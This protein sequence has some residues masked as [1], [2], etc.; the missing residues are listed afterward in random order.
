MWRALNSKLRKGSCRKMRLGDQIQKGSSEKDSERLLQFWAW[1][2]FPYHDF[3][4][5]KQ[6][7]SWTS[8]YLLRGLFKAE[9]SIHK[10]MGNALPELQWSHSNSQIGNIAANNLTHF[11]SIYPLPR[12]VKMPTSL[13]RDSQSVSSCTQLSWVFR[14]TKNENSWQSIKCQHSQR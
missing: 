14:T 9:L 11:I 4:R 2:E 8:S 6:S 12:W 1:K 3:H 13:L 7:S 10:V 5:D